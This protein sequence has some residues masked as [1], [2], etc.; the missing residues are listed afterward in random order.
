MLKN[1]NAII[2]SGFLEIPSI[3]FSSIRC[4][5]IRSKGIIQYKSFKMRYKCSVEDVLKHLRKS[6]ST[7]QN[8]AQD[9]PCMQGLCLMAV[10][11]QVSLVLQ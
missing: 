10:Q 4:S 2:I 6:K 5:D 7:S 1:M 11:D 8:T 3:C 9:E